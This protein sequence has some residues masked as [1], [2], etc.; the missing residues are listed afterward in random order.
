[1]SY[2]V[3]QTKRV[4]IEVLRSTGLKEVNKKINSESLYSITTNNNG[5]IES[6]DFNT[7]VINDVML[8]VAKNVRKRLKEV[9]EG[10]NLPEEMYTNVKDKNI[11][12]GVMYEVPLGIGFNNAFL[13]DSGPKIP[14]KIKYSGNVSLDIKTRVSSYGINSALI[15]IYIYVEVTQRT[16]IPYSSKDVKLTSEIPVVLKVVKGSIPNYITS[17]NQSYSL[18]IN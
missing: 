4:G 15:E 7:S 13:A 1:M 18:P 3:V 2:A 14:V 10:K 5:E 12:H 11:K 9:E 16:I 6:I 17:N 8:I